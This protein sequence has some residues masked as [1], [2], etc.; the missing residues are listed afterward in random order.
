MVE[1]KELGNTII[2]NSRIEE[3]GR[4]LEKIGAYMERKNY[5]GIKYKRLMG[6]L[7]EAVANAVI[8]GNREDERKG[9]A[10]TYFDDDDQF[11]IKVRDEGEGFDL[12]FIGDPCLPENITKSH[13]RGVFIIRSFVDGLSF[14]DKGNEITLTIK[15]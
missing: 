8:H 6:A 14:N 3:I 13:G 9:V 1:N 7:H 12:S 11:Q 10:V 15:K 4:V 2:I 5:V